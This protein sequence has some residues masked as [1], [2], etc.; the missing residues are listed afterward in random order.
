VVHARSKPPFKEGAKSL[1][2]RAT[3]KKAE[4]SEVPRSAAVP[5][6]LRE[7]VIEVETTGDSRE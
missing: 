1:V 6:P 2:A 4:S 5:M 7:I 3:A